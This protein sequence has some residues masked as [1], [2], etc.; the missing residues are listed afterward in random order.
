MQIRDEEVKNL[1]NRK[2]WSLIDESTQM[3]VNTTLVSAV[4]LELMRRNQLNTDNRWK[5]PH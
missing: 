3:R 1:C 4:M 2:L 5:M